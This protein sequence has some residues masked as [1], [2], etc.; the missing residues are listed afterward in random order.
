MYVLGSE[1]NYIVRYEDGQQQA[2]W[3]KHM[4]MTAR[5]WH[6]VQHHRSDSPEAWAAVREHERTS[7]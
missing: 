4:P 2:A 7:Q 1:W 3:I 5:S 6:G